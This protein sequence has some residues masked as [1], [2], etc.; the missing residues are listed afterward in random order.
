MK[1]FIA[2]L[3]VTTACYANINA[4]QVVGTQSFSW[5]DK[6][7]IDPES[8]QAHTVEV[9]M[10]YPT[11]GW[12]IMG[13]PVQ[14]ATPFL[15]SNAVDRRD[16]HDLAEIQYHPY[17]VVIV[18]HHNAITYERCSAL[19]QSLA[20]NKFVVITVKSNQDTTDETF[21]ADVEFMC[22]QVVG[23]FFKEESWALFLLRDSSWRTKLK[24]NGIPVICDFNN[25]G[26]VAASASSI[27]TSQLFLQ[28]NHIKAYA[29][30]FDSDASMQ[31]NKPVL[32]CNAYTNTNDIIDFLDK[33]L[34]EPSKTCII[35]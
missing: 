20:H 32:T 7:R 28:H 31:T 1:N 30:L 29:F 34:H 23:D 17:P 24:F 13:E 3:V 16:N 6:N 33:N 14:G 25:I 26:I 18:S 9:Q 12:Q 11:E 8:L 27:K 19:C 4:M 35:S 10:W 5:S 15:R 21:L 2:F 22:E